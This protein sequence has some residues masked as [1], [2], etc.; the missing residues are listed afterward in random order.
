MKP[1]S[2]P[3]TTESS[4]REPSVGAR[5]N[6]GRSANAPQRNTST[7][8][9]SNPVS[10]RRKLNVGAPGGR[11]PSNGRPTTRGKD[12]GADVLSL[13]PASSAGINPATIFIPDK[14]DKTNYNQVLFLMRQRLARTEELLE[15]AQ[16][17]HA[18]L[19][20]DHKAA[21]DQANREHRVQSKE[22]TA[23]INR[24]RAAKE[25]ALAAARRA[26]SE[27]D[28]WKVRHA[29]VQAELETTAARLSAESK[30]LG[31]AHAMIE[32]QRTSHS[33]AQ[34]DRTA[35]LLSVRQELSA[36]QSSVQTLQAQLQVHMDAHAKNRSYTQ[37]YEQLIVT[38]REKLGES[39]RKAIA[40]A[41]WKTKAAQCLDDWSAE[42]GRL[43][44][45]I[46]KQSDIE[47]TLRRHLHDYRAIL[48]YVAVRGFVSQFLLRKALRRLFVQTA[49][50]ATRHLIEQTEAQPRVHPS[51][52]HESI[53]ELEVRNSKLLNEWPW[54]GLRKPPSLNNGAG[55]TAVGDSP[56]AGSD[57]TA[58]GS[59]LQ[60][61]LVSGANVNMQVFPPLTACV[62]SISA[63]L[64]VLSES[65]SLIFA[66]KRH[67]ASTA[68]SF[69]KRNIELT[70]SF[71]VSDHELLAAKKKS[72][73]LRSHTRTLQASVQEKEAALTSALSE[74][75][76]VAAELHEVSR[77]SA[78]EKSQIN[79]LHA[80]KFE[81]SVELT[82]RVHTLQSELRA[83]QVQRQR[84]SKEVAD[85][86][87]TAAFI[88][89]T[90]EEANENERATLKQQVAQ[91]KAL[92]GWAVRDNQ[93]AISPTRG[94]LSAEGAPRARSPAR[95]AGQTVHRALLPAP[96]PP[97]ELFE[98][99]ATTP[100][101][102]THALRPHP[103]L[104]PPASSMA[105]SVDSLAN[106]VAVQ[107]PVTAT[108]H[109]R[110]MSAHDPSAVA[111]PSTAP[112][113]PLTPSIFPS[114][115]GA[116]ATAA[117]SGGVIQRATGRP[118]SSPSEFGALSQALAAGAAAAAAAARPDTRASFDP[119]RGDEYARG[120]PS[121]LSTPH[122]QQRAGTAGAHTSRTARAAQ[123][124]PMFA[125][126]GS[127]TAR[128]SSSSSSSSP[129]VAPPV[130]ASAS[131]VSPPIS[132]YVMPPRRRPAS[133]SG[134]ARA[135]N[136][137]ILDAAMQRAAAR[138]RTDKKTTHA[139]HRGTQAD[140]RRQASPSPTR[141]ALHKEEKEATSAASMPPPPPP[142]AS[143]KEALSHAA[144]HAPA[145]QSQ[146][147]L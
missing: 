31:D 40:A 29:A 32:A 69:F 90:K 66:Q 77:T 103:P 54:G 3:N 43:K 106:L 9:N 70:N 38:L 51:V 107:R 37:Q 75:A 119:Y 72:I 41:Q 18:S 57:K 5:P 140:G 131:A 128:P 122:P 16:A 120:D 80:A 108:S 45:K 48:K 42:R 73:A 130:A 12:D 118:V 95:A 82:R 98:Q 113:A 33:A 46:A 92:L 141:T 4:K 55:G 59:S 88:E 126:Y 22:M 121:S 147:E 135:L 50:L 96:T 58:I 86:S 36:T 27:R 24:E 94:M 7:G 61:S 100:S 21:T 114:P 83:L 133:G 110:T 115:F 116:T 139:R 105:G 89:Y 146:P 49:A 44:R 64:N 15:E 6:T 137:T 65:S 39:E 143:L 60:S 93:L 14:V 26:E 78:L 63:Q 23:E 62:S 134:A 124:R 11:T 79:L 123:Y 81:R 112:A 67:W 8:K 138:Q 125:A 84:I 52:Q 56:P 109:P 74:K 1:T 76:R 97:V 132:V 111:P 104:M 117:M 102:A 127:L 142:V 20:S 47:K 87:S 53:N 30:R 10:P 91:Q 145:A 129:P 68:D 85:E 35:E 13:T 144:A 17:R 25:E 101:N 71:L 136:R 28:A 2:R 99:K 19:A 34:S